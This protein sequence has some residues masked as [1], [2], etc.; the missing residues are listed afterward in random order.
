M[1]YY[2]VFARK[3]ESSDVFRGEVW[4][5]YESDYIEHCNIKEGYLLEELVHIF[6][7][8]NNLRAGEKGYLNCHI[9]AGSS[10]W[11]EI[12]NNQIDYKYLGDLIGGPQPS[13]LIALYDKVMYFIKEGDRIVEEL[14]QQE[15]QEENERKKETNR[16]NKIKIK[17]ERKKLYQQLKKEFES[18]K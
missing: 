5:S 6:R 14:K 16:L 10:D 1:K 9:F 8:N 3:P 2:C 4:K 15:L 12:E 7:T 13:E 18:K 11:A 17:E